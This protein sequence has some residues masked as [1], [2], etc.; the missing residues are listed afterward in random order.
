MKAFFLEKHT[1]SKECLLF[2]RKFQAIF[3]RKSFV[4]T[5]HLFSITPTSTSAAKKVGES[6]DVFTKRVFVENNISGIM[7]V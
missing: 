5:P 1:F 3:V 6:W 4:L 7:I 2:F